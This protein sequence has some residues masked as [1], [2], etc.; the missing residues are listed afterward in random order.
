MTGLTESNSGKVGWLNKNVIT[1]LLA[2]RNANGDLTVHQ[3]SG[4][5]MLTDEWMRVS[6]SSLLVHC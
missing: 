6:V 4:L 2:Y 1:S 5:M 3:T